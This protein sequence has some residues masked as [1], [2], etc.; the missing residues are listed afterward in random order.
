FRATKTSWSI[1]CVL[2]KFCDM[3]I[4]GIWRIRSGARGV[5]SPCHRRRRN[6]SHSFRCRWA[7]LLVMSIGALNAADELIELAL[8]QRN[9]VVVIVLALDLRNLAVPS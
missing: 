9:L 4:T 1:S 7:S 8:D 6:A 2:T 5:P 3:K